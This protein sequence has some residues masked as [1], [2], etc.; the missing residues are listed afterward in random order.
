MIFYSSLSFGHLDHFLGTN[1]Y[2]SPLFTTL[3]EGGFY[4][5]DVYMAKYCT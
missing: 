1:I 5:N 4:I 2:A 3:L